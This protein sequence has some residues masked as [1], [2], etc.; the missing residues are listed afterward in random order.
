MNNPEFRI[1]ALDIG[2]VRIGVAVSDPLG[3]SGQPLQVIRRT[4]EERTLDEID[5]VVQQYQAK[6]IVVGLPR[7]M[8]GSLGAMAKKIQQFAKILAERFPQSEIVFWDE[9]LTTVQ[10]EK[11]LIEAGTSRKKRKQKVDKIAA[12]IMLQ[13]YLDYLGNQAGSSGD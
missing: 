7:S 1:L 8:D 3:I 6:R 5:K 2:D 11:L 9:R 4:S 13:S 12:A 10:S